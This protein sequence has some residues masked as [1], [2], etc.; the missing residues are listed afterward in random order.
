MI[1]LKNVNFTYHTV[2]ETPTGV[3]DINLSIKKGECVVLC[4]RSGCG[5]S[6]LLRI[7]NGLIPNFYEGNLLGRVHVNGLDLR[8]EGLYEISKTVGSVFQNPSTQFFNVDTNSELVFACENHGRSKAYMDKQL[9]EVTGKFNLD[10]LL[11]RSIFELSGGEKQRIA[12]ASVYASEPDIFVMD[13]PTANLDKSAIIGLS[14]IIQNLKAEGKT[15]VI[16]E[17]QLYYLKDVADRYVYLEDGR[18]K[19]VYESAEFNT[20]SN[21]YLAQM[22]LRANHLPS[23]RPCNSSQDQERLALT[24]KSLNFKR[25]KKTILDIP[26]LSFYQGEVVAVVGENG[27][28]KSTLIKCLS[29]MLK[30]KAQIKLKE[31]KH[32]CK[33]MPEKCFVVMQDVNEQLF[34]ASVEDEVCLNICDTNPGR[35]QSILDQLSLTHKAQ[36]HP[37]ALS[38]GE[39]QRTAI[40]SALVAKKQVLIFD[41]P[42]SGLDFRSMEQM[43]QLIR[44]VVSSVFCVIIVTHDDQLIERCCDRVIKMEAGQVTDSFYIEE[45][46]AMI[47]DNKAMEVTE[48]VKETAIA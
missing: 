43:S 4:G 18:I 33:N 45:H 44:N 29:G 1:E 17:H 47:E 8:K 13:E 14:K 25:G 22:G 5:K 10:T 7:M 15:V 27:A 11:E 31:E 38:G 12:C 24:I 23:I 28:G 20:F 41:E 39:K 9:A 34:G 6:T 30:T 32:K 48:N 42:T 35:T 2:D 46:K 21:E 40:A 36:M 16:S 26:D 3:C 37:M 19:Q